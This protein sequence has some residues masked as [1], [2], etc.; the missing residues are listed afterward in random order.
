MNKTN[1]VKIYINTDKNGYKY[2]LILIHN[3]KYKQY[4][5]DNNIIY[6][7]FV[8]IQFLYKYGFV[9]IKNVRI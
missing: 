5:L 6:T 8:I 9:K 7:F 1:K 3:I 4:I 2:F